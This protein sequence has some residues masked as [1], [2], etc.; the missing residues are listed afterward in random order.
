MDCVI[1][2]GGI[3]GLQAALTLR[4]FWPEK[5]VT[6]VDAEQ[7]IGYYRTL[8]PQFMVRTLAEKKIFFWQAESDPSLKV[9]TG[10]KVESLDRKNQTLY[11]GNK[12][13]LEYGHLILAAGG[14]PIIPPICPHNSCNGIFPVRSLSVVRLVRE[15][16]PDHPEV[17]ILGGGLVGVKTAIHLA[18]A[19][20]PV[21]LIEKEKGLLPQALSPQAA[22]V[23]ASHLEQK[24]VRVLLGCSVEDIQLDSGTVR[25]VQ[26][27][28]KWIQC[29]TLLVAAGSIPDV[30]FLEG[31][32]LLEDGA[33]AVSTALQSSDDKIF[34]AGDLVTIT[35]DHNLT[36]WTWPQAASQGKLAAL[37]L[38]KPTPV[39]LTCLTRVNSM[40]L[41]GL[42]LIV[43]GVPVPGSKIMQFSR[44]DA[45][46]HRELFIVDGK[47]VGG[48]LV[49]DLS[50]AGRLHAMMNTGEE[51]IETDDDI[52]KPSGRTFSPLARN[53]AGQH[54]RAWVVTPAKD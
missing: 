26:T 5:T 54:R 13:K 45:G 7:E 12:E 10:C 23:V 21:T 52:V 11:L 6:L 4:Q 40:D 20:L 37:N 24:N 8:L 15:W 43:L 39:P 51:V 33:L 44:P 3:A 27:G 19:N 31:S 18:H 49:G 16:L 42:A 14:R 30:D 47:I 9:R 28:G 35:G 25:A 17:V 41:K 36:P 29:R 1:V 50:D 34:A 46:V 53:A 2:G 22:A 48:A 38:F 32:G